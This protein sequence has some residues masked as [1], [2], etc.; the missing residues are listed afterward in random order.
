VK[1]G[2]PT[3]LRFLQAAESQGIREAFEVKML[4]AEF[5]RSSDAIFLQFGKLLRI[6]KEIKYLTM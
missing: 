1:K 3:V 6:S 4:S 2:D 5:G